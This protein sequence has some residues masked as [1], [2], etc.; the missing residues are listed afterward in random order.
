MRMEQKF[1]DPITIKDHPA[2]FWGLCN[3]DDATRG[4]PTMREG[5]QNKLHFF[6]FSE[7]PLRPTD[8]E[9]SKTD[10][11]YNIRLADEHAAFINY[12][13]GDGLEADARRHYGDERFA[14]MFLCNKTEKRQHEDIRRFG[15]HAYHH[16]DLILEME[17][18]EPHTA[19]IDFLCSTLLDKRPVL[20]GTA[21]TI[22]GFVEEALTEL[23]SGAIAKQRTKEWNDLIG[24]Q[25][26]KTIGYLLRRAAS[27]TDRVSKDGVAR[28][29]T[30]RWAIDFP[31]PESPERATE[32]QQLV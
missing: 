1:R 22:I 3:D 27:Q 10:T 12:L 20:R 11:D 2:V 17:R 9:D 31:P 30:T 7:V 8:R 13:M 21:R 25:P 14:E 15:M 5:S 26:V 24:K 19:L 28:D 18:M 4:L 23:G 29:K 16:D 6:K 32:Q